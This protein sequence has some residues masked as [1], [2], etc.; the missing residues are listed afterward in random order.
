[1]T[2]P[3]VATKRR[4]GGELRCTLCKGLKVTAHSNGK[5]QSSNKQSM[6]IAATACVSAAGMQQAVKAGSTTM[7]Y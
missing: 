6:V 5:R 3:A 7:G 2:L 4:I 1:M